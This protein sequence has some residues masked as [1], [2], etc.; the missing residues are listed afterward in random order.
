MRSGKRPDGPSFAEAV[1]CGMNRNFI[2]KQSQNLP[3]QLLQP[4]F[5]RFNQTNAAGS[6]CEDSVVIVPQLLAAF[7]AAPQALEIGEPLQFFRTEPKPYRQPSRGFD[8]RNTPGR[9]CSD[10]L[11]LLRLSQPLTNRK[12]AG[13]L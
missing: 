5:G 2:E 12:F 13:V 9:G 11:H 7:S 1:D 10:R 3:L 6:F 8:R 4:R